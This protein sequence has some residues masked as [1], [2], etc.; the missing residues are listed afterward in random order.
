MMTDLEKAAALWGASE[1]RKRVV[2]YLRA[3]EYHAAAGAIEHGAH[4]D[5]KFNPEETDQGAARFQQ[6]ADRKTMHKL[7]DSEDLLG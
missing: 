1:E 2:A 3:E 4:A 7:D 5:T 6:R